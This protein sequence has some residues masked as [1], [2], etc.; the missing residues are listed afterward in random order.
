MY[1]GSLIDDL[2]ATVQRAESSTGVELDEPS[3]PE[4]WFA[5]LPTEMLALESAPQLAGVA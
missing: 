4:A 2:I 3:R 5:M 1:T